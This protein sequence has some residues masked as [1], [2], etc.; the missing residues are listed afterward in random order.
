MLSSVR[1]HRWT[2]RLQTQAGE[3]VSNKVGELADVGAVWYYPKGVASML[4]KFR[5]VVH[6]KWKMTHNTEACHKTKDVKDLSYDAMTPQ[7]FE[8]KCIPNS[9]GLRVYKVNP[10]NKGRT[11]G[12]NPDDNESIFCGSCHVVMESDGSEAE[13]VSIDTGDGKMATGVKEDKKMMTL[14][15]RL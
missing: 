14:T 3:C 11:F 8:Y 5:M 13:D 7:W 4:S 15:E 9:Q 10:K 6:S 1:K 12:A 2:L